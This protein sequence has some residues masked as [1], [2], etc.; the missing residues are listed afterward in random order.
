MNT[1]NL[2]GFEKAQLPPVEGEIRE[3]KDGKY[4][5]NGGRWSK[6]IE[7]SNLTLKELPDIFKKLDNLAKTGETDSS[8]KYFA[9]LRKK[10]PDID[11]K[12]DIYQ[13]LNKLGK[14]Y[15]KLDLSPFREE[16]K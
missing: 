13:R 1:L 3:W 10:Y 11:K 7:E 5:F 9:E 15:A 14:Y 16:M 4:Q 2:N 12:I 6:I 8:I